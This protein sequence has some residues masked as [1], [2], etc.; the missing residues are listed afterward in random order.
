MALRKEGWER[1]IDEGWMRDR[2]GM[3][4]WGSP[5]LCL[6]AVSECACKKGALH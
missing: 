3:N 4:W 1:G 6:I 2:G 5:A